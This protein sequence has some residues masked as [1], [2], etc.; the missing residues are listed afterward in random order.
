VGSAAFLLALVV[1]LT[2]LAGGAA[3]VIALLAFA[4]ETYLFFRAGR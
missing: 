4:W 3:V 2:G 1:A